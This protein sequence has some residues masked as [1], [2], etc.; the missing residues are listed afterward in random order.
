[1]IKTH[2]HTL[3]QPTMF[4]TS[5][6]TRTLIHIYKETKQQK[7]RNCYILMKEKTYTKIREKRDKNTTCKTSIICDSKNMRAQAKKTR[8]FH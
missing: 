5:Y 7:S 4:S 8:L 2:G 6:R 1:M 3:N